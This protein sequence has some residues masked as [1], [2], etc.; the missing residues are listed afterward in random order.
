MLS[1]HVQRSNAF[2]HPARNPETENVPGW[3]RV[4]SYAFE[5]DTPLF[6]RRELLKDLMDGL[7]E[8]AHILLRI[9]G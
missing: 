8:L 4:A 9:I 7:V 1:V 2:S 5:A 6:V 3:L